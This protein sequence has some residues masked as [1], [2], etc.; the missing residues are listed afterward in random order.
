MLH[1]LGRS[2]MVIDHGHASYPERVQYRS[3]EFHQGSIFPQDGSRVLIKT[4]SFRNQ[5]EKIVA[6][7][8][9][10]FSRSDFGAH[11]ESAEKSGWKAP[12]AF[13]Q[14]HVGNDR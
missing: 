12:V 1:E 6:L 4:H 14:T 13:H 11:I 2:R 10:E 5:G 9:A 3:I 8:I 7:F